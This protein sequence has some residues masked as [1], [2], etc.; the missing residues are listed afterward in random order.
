MHKK[1]D[2]FCFGGRHPT[3]VNLEHL[4]YMYM[5]KENAKRLVFVFSTAPLYI[6]LPDE[7]TAKTCFEQLLKAWV[8]DVVEPQQKD[9]D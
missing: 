8:G 2:L 6:D 3:A 5:D 4:N 9:Q 7:E 1:R